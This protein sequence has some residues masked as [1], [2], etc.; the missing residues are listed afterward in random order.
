MNTRETQCL[1][2]CRDVPKKRVASPLT[3]EHKGKCRGS[4]ETV[5][6][7]CILTPVLVGQTN[8]L[9]AVKNISGKQSDT[10]TRDDFAKD[11][12][13]EQINRDTKGLHGL[14]GKERSQQRRQIVKKQLTE[15]PQV[16]TRQGEPIL[17]GSK[18]LECLAQRKT[19][20]S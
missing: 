6:L 17:E 18:F 13:V 2:R 5:G 14:N 4:V 20:S 12:L 15:R 8:S 19:T 16:P 3:V 7:G 10:D 11:I 9:P 1:A